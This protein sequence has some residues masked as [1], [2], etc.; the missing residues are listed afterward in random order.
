MAR[1]EFRTERRRD[2]E[3]N[4]HKIVMDIDVRSLGDR[5]RDLDHTRLKLGLGRHPYQIARFRPRRESNAAPLLI[6]HW[7]WWAPEESFL[8]QDL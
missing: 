7:S 8:F 4:P 5:G 2:R 1:Y 3:G 6:T